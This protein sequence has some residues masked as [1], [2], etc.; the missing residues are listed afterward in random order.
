MENVIQFPY[1]FDQKTLN[2]QALQVL[3]DSHRFQVL[4]WHRK[5]R[6]TTLA[7]NQLIRWAAAVR[8]PFWYVGPSY[9]LAKDTIW[10]DPRM[11]PYYIPDWT[12]P[13]STLIKKRE[14]ELRVDFLTSGG[15]IYVY[16]SDRPELMR[17]PN[18]MGVVIDEYAVMRFEVWEEI[19][20][21]VMR[22]NPQAWCWFLF[23]PRGK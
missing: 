6:K 1:R 8:A 18:P 13:N 17:G 10:N 5:A 19:I 12:N 14:T 15:Q 11:F 16:G 4:N 9:G 21:P 3:Q 2:P 23:T 20:Q 7:I 22:S